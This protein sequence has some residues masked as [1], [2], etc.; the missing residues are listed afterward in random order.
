MLGNHS[1]CGEDTLSALSDEAAYRKH[2]GEV[3]GFVPG[4][5]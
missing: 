3:I 4:R 1:P 5:A 2:G